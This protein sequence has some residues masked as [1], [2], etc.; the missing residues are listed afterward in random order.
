MTAGRLSA[1]PGHPRKLFILLSMQI[2]VSMPCLPGWEDED[3]DRTLSLLTV[4][5]RETQRKEDMASI[6]NRDI[7]LVGSI[8]LASAEDVFGTVASVLGESASWAGLV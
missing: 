3:V 1:P 7:L 4:S 5:P 2:C 6:K 8:R